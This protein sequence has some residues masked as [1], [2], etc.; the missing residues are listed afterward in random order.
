MGGV[1]GGEVE[2]EEQGGERGRRRAGAEREGR[3]G[4][5]G[6]KDVARMRK[7]I[8]G[9]R[10]KGYVPHGTGQIQPRHPARHWSNPAQ[11][12]RTALVKSSVIHHFWVRPG[13]P[14]ALIK[15]V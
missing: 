2:E 4:R 3:G 5:S 14:A 7:K 13:P 6:G 9:M 8:S 10:I 12:S 1:G 11:A 15:P